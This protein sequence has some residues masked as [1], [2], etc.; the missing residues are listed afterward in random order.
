MEKILFEEQQ[1][2]RQWWILAIPILLMAVFAYAIF[3]QE[4]TGVPFGNK[5]ASSLSIGIFMLI[6]IGLFW[7]FWSL[8]LTTKI[9]KKAINIDFGILGKRQILLTEIK[10]ADVMTYSPLK[11]YGGWGLRISHNGTAYNMAGKLGL[12]VNTQ[13]GKKIMIGTQKAKE[14]KRVME[15][16]LP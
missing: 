16:L 11:D 6:P 4:V 13:S 3:Q 8:K 10:K 15:Q 1:R 14:L 2:M 5:P 9:T 12:L 7:F